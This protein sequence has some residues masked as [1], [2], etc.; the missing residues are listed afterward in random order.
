MAQALKPINGGGLQLYPFN[1]HKRWIVT[2]TNYRN[3]LFQHS[4]V[5]GVSPLYKELVPLS[6]S[7]NMVNVADDSQL[8]NTNSNN[9]TYL[10]KK[11]Q[12][13]IWSG[14]NQT[15]FKHRPNNERDLFASAS[16]FSI[17]MNRLGDGILPGSVII[18]DKSQHDLVEYVNI[19]DRKID[20]MHG[21][22][23]DTSLNTGSYVP[24]GDLMG[25][26]GF[27]DELVPR[28]S[29]FD[30]KIEDRSGYQNHAVG[31][32]VYYGRGI[33]TTGTA[34]ITSGTKIGFNG[35]NS[36]L[37]IDNKPRYTP[38]K[39][40]DYSLSIW[41]ELPVSQSNVSSNYNW[42][43]NKNGTVNEEYTNK[44]GDPLRRQ[45]NV[46]TPIFPYD[47]K[48]YNQ[49]NGVGSSGKLVATLSDGIR[50]V[51][52]TSSTKINDG[53]QHHVV[54]NKTGSFLELW[55]DG[56][57]EASSSIKLKGDVW[58]ENDLLLGSQHISD[59]KRYGTTP[60][61]RSKTP[62]I[63][64]FNTITGSLDEFRYYRK[65]L[66]TKEIQGLSSNDWNTGSA[67]QEDIV[68]EVFYNSGIVVV[69]DPRPK[70]RHVLVGDG[71]WNYSS[72]RLGFIT[73]YKSTKKLYETS[74]MCEV[75]SSEFNVSTNPSLRKNNDVREYF[76]Q[77]FV[78]GSDFAPYFTSI[79]LYN[80]DGDLL[81]I[82]KLASAIQNRNDVDITVKI[83][84]DMDG[85]FGTPKT[86]SLLPN[87]PRLGLQKRVDAKGTTTYAWNSQGF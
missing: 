74:V 33:K 53:N 54:F 3:D 68:G 86:G 28:S 1:A 63:T 40:N 39:G 70:Y 18:Q 57:K 51:E 27:N 2:D 6:Q 43:I 65:A 59:L 15:F 76:L 22:L 48:V 5:R 44:K 42:I 64:N 72:G 30:R 79:G 77:P 69:S 80:K 34:S 67:Y 13:V 61:S 73:K 52:V 14:L 81:A 71:N 37:K 55:V 31:R 20:E 49:S 75:G 23:I 32:E 46:V 9:N 26:W 25:Y 60:K 36:Y 45:R 29:S 83:R 62:E 58:N 84:L 66:S 56:T 7:V 17:P 11:E 24:F 50:N 21:Y 16:V 8:D 19:V 10:A 38:V 87:K 85:P 41:T 47:L 82:G 4:I 78:T 35:E 12:K